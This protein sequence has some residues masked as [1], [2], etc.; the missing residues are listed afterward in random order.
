MPTIY[1][2]KPYRPNQGPIVGI[3]ETRR[4][5]INGPDSAAT[6]RYI[7]DPLCLAPRTS[8]HSSGSTQR[9]HQSQS[10]PGKSYNMAQPGPNSVDCSSSG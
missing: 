2:I 10:P 8:L 1:S 7:R 4:G 3:Q 9:Q 6:P 5:H